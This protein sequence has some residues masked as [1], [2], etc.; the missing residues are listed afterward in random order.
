M[1]TLIYGLAP[2]ETRDYMESLLSTNCKNEDDIQ[3][4][5]SAASNAGYHSFRITTYNGEA[6]N[7]A[8]T[9]NI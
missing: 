3:K 9:L 1:E 5:I 6:P 8:N 7:F 4:I 2:N